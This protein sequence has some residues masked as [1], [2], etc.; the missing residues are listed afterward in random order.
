MLRT[1]ELLLRLKIV[2]NGEL[3]KVMLWYLTFG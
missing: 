1:F 3:T 2:M